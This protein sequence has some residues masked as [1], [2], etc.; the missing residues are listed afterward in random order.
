M[1]DLMPFRDRRRRRSGSPAE[2]AFDNFLTDTMDMFRS[3]FK[4]DVIEED[5]Q[6]IIEAEL[7]GLDRDDI[8]IELQDNILCI[9]AQ[10]EEEDEIED[11][12][13]IRRERR[14]GSFQRNFQLENVDE[15]GITAEFDSGVL[16]VCLPKEEP[17]R[18]ERRTI[19]IE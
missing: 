14:T 7:P 1:F 2:S 19:D 5:D 10:H 18:K 3:S 16:K 4:T 15:E 17:E 6:F 13:Y 12:D 11:R 8:N 9:S